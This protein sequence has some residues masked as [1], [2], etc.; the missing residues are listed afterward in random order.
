MTHNLLTRNLN[1][2]HGR[3]NIMVPFG[4]VV[5][6]IYDT[7]CDIIKKHNDF[8]VKE[9]ANAKNIIKETNN[10]NYKKIKQM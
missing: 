2:S 1:S 10:G 4:A 8:V 3:P 5:S 7:G 9:Y 6:L